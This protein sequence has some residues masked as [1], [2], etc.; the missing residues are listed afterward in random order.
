M[1]KWT[2]F[3]GIIFNCF[4]LASLTGAVVVA[5]LTFMSIIVRGYCFSFEPIKAILY[6]EFSIFVFSAIYLGYIIQKYIRETIFANTKKGLKNG[7][8]SCG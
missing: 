4:G 3:A 2:R 1:I 8:E 7:K 6:T 5:V